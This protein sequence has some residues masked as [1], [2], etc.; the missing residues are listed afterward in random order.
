MKYRTLGRTGLSVSEVGFG[1]G[2]IGYVWGPTTDAEVIRSI[3]RAMELGINF[4]DVAPG[5]GNGK[6]EELLGQA[7]QGRRGEILITTKVSIP[8]E[9]MGDIRGYTLRSVDV[10]LRRLRT[11]YLDI[12]LAHNSITSRRGAV[13]RNAITSADALTMADAFK[14]LQRAGKVRYIGFT[15]WRCNRNELLKLI[16]SGVFDV[17][18][19][20]Y[21]ILNQSAQTSPPPS[22]DRVDVATVEAQ[23]H[24]LP[25]YFLVD[26]CQT[27]PQA[28][29]HNMGVIGIRPLLAGFLSEGLDRPLDP[30]PHVE[31]ML[32]RV[33]SLDFLKQ[34]GKRTLSRAAFIFCL[35]NPG[36]ATIIPGVKN[37][38]E[39]EEAAACSGARPL[40]KADLTRIA[41]LYQRD[42]A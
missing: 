5:Y 24:E 35:M 6:A 31:R 32:R 25:D 30:A 18:Q 29:A 2:G 19:T 10:S 26:Q 39:I 27:I 34:K 16:E 36:I 23:G 28:R 21:N 14:E 4:Y 3:H 8:S 37:T 17:L 42:F 9:E 11:D 41:E 22:V 20:E 40:S 13:T 15:A 7:V 38:A 33:Q 1:G 12:L